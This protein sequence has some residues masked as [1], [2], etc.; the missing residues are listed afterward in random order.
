[1]TGWGCTA[2][3]WVWPRGREPGITGAAERMVVAAGIRQAGPG[4]GH[5]H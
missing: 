1:M 2:S 3:S 4:S 5:R